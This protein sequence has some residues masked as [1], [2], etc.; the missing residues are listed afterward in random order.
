M[1]SVIGWDL[2]GANLKLAHL[3]GGRVVQVAQIPCPAWQDAN[4]FD[5]ALEEGLLLCPSGAMHAVTMT[6]EMSDVFADRAE[7]VAY[8]VDMMHRATDA[9]VLFYGGEAGFLDRIRAVEQ[10]SQVASANWHA[11]AAIIAQSLPEGLLLDIGTTTTDLVPFK[12][13]TVAARCYTD[14]ERLAGG[15]LIYTGVVRTPVM[16]VAR[17]APFNGRLQRIA[18]E[19]FA[20]MADVWR[21]MG[22]LPEDAD[23]YPTPDLRGKSMQQS[24]A[25]LARM[26]GRDLGDASLLAFVDVARHFA[27]CQVAEIEAAASAL[28][29]REAMSDAARVIGAGY[30]R[31]IARQV[32]QRLGR[33][34]AN[35]AELIDCTPD[36][37]A[38][39]AVCAP[40]VAVGILAG[41]VFV[42]DMRGDGGG[43]RDPPPGR[44]LTGERV[45][46]PEHHDGADDRHDHA[47]DIEAGD[48]GC[49]DGREQI[50]ADNRT[51]DAEHDVEQ[52]T[53]TGADED[54]AGDEASDQTQHN[55]G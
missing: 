50:A 1:A 47:V 14:G 18:A 22:E 12:N 32:A 3:A 55:P 7:G 51:D 36:T 8:L 6:G 29:S 35:F 38:M 31:F 40:A 27:E 9:E 52:H 13:G 5:A 46:E 48:A 2:G 21:L 19:R 54:F 42:P 10:S 25:R 43:H 41:R 4:K 45:V 17:S 24:A 49:A 34:C 15:E 33:P 39:A 11:S 20:T 23:P 53:L 28:L 26:F 30:G 37:S 44:K 16:A